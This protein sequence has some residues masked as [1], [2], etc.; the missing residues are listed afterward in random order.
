MTHIVGFACKKLAGSL[1]L[2]LLWNR[3]ERRPPTTRT[4]DVPAYQ[5]RRTY[6]EMRAR[7]RRECDH[8]SVLQL[9]CIAV[10][11]TAIGFPIA[12]GRVTGGISKGG[13]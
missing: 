7:R 6:E 12:V 11:E 1:M 3:T 5:R 13:F 4:C 10:T 2:I 9:V 8:V